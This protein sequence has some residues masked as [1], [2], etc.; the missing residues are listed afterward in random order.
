MSGLSERIKIYIDVVA[1]GASS[2][3][4]GF[5]Q[6]VAEADGVTGK[7]KA[8]ASSA[9][10]SIK[11]NAGAL[12]AAGIAAFGAFAMKAG[13]AFRDTSIAA[14]K[15]SDTVGISVQDAS[16]W[17]E[18]AGDLGI[19]ADAVQ[20]AMQKMNKGIA[21]GKPV[22]SE[23]GDVIVRT[24]DGLVDSNATFIETIDA[25]SKIKDPTD[26]AAAAQD[27]FGKGY[28]SMAELTKM[29][30][31]ELRKKLA[32]VSDQKVIDDGELAKAKTWR[33]RWDNLKDT[34]EDV[35]LGVGSLVTSLS[36][37]FSVIAS[38]AQ[39]VIGLTTAVVDFIFESN[40]AKMTEGIRAIADETNS[41]GARMNAFI[42]AVGAMPDSMSKFDKVTTGLKALGDGMTDLGE[43]TTRTDIQFGFFKQ[44]FDDLAKASPETAAQVLRDMDKLLSGTDA[45]SVKFQEWAAS[46]GLTNDRF[47][48]LADSLPT[49]TQKVEDMKAAADPAAVALQEAG[50]QAAIAAGKSDRLKD[51]VVTLTEKWQILKG[52]LDDREAFLNLEQ[53]F[54]DLKVKGQDAWDAAATGAADAT[55]KSRDYELA[56]I[57]AKQKVIDYLAEVLKLPPERSTS[58]LAAYDQGQFD[59]VEAQLNI[60]T[61][62]RTMNVSIQANGGIG[63]A[64]L[65]QPH[66][67]KG[68]PVRAGEAIVVG[69]NP[70]GSLNSTSELVVPQGP[71]NVVSAPDIRRALGASDAVQQYVDNS[72]THITLPAGSDPRSVLAAQRKY[73]RI[74]GAT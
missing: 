4:K 71:S 66:K 74:Q 3:I 42:D 31:E 73:R 52:N 67:A 47:N 59:W 6:S 35:Q 45:T 46:V 33:E 55:S 23:L 29:S 70:D 48:E 57:G 56:T 28:G 20:G 64:P 13:E 2:Q 37:L 19:G 34:F 49:A 54:D 44:T 26:R 72:I 68:G 62:N 27:A 61:R 5:R 9:F 63:Y 21:D 65:N 69:D 18:V 60:L 11:A 1:D 22:F 58:I 50:N 51:S 16:R 8:G 14:G 24:K 41:A 25:I 30:A 43:Q 17:M 7:F 12:A 39:K 10:D 36:P 15:F 53:S 38:G 40:Q 32:E